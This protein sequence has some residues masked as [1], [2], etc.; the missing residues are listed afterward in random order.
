MMEAYFNQPDDVKARDAR[1]E[2]SY[3]V[4]STPSHVELPRDH[5]ERMRAFKDADRPLSLCPPELD[6]KWRFF[7]RVGE[8]PKVG[9]RRRVCPCRRRVCFCVCERTRARWCVSHPLCPRVRR[10]SPVSRR[11]L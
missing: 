2:I 7:W 10:V 3:Q 1:P 4:G 9:R 5:C 8:R 11:G 6:P